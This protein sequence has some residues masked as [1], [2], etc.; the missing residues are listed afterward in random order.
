LAT[1]RD[2]W[3][4]AL[5]PDDD[6][7]L[8]TERL[9][10]LFGVA[11]KRLGFASHHLE[12]QSRFRFSGPNRRPFSPI[13]TIWMAALAASGIH[14]KFPARSTICYSRRGRMRVERIREL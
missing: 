7:G 6:A 3:G 11:A 8:S 14:D 10:D 1:L 5:N 4:A 12:T 13:P 2:L 9:L